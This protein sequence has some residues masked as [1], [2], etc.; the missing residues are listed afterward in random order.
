MTSPRIVENQEVMSAQ[1]Q[2]LC[3]WKRVNHKDCDMQ[4]DYKRVFCSKVAYSLTTVLSY[5]IPSSTSTWDSV[6]NCP[7][8][9]EGIVNLVSEAS[10]PTAQG[11][12]MIEKEIHRWAR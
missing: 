6:R 1:K 2:S 3:S 10:Q 7:Q 12:W 5:Q 9:I 11:L 8:V 4:H